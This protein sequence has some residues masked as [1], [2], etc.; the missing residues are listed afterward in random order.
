ML[1]AISPPL[2]S[3][4]FMPILIIYFDDAAEIISSPA[5]LRRRDA[6]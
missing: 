4:H 2:M 6:A 3:L 5:A 1:I